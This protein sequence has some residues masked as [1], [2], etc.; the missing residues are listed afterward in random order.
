MTSP[1]VRLAEPLSWIAVLLAAT[2][3]VLFALMGTDV[4]PGSE[5]LA[6]VSFLAGLLAPVFAIVAYA[7]TKLSGSRV[8]RVTVWSLVL[9]LIAALWPALFFLAFFNCPSGVC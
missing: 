1:W 7:L 9:G 5:P 3:I 6:F 4:V 2:M 8:S